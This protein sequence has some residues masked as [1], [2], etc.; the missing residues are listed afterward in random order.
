ML[1]FISL[2][3]ATIAVVI[4]YFV[5]F[6]ATR[7]A[8]SIR[9]FGQVLAAWMFLLAGVVV[10]G[11]LVAPMTG[12]RSPVMDMTEHMQRMEQQNEEILRE[13]QEE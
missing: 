12:F 10:L 7:A 11:G 13:L 8:G 5:L 3:P 9:R 4:G 2:I 1:F 6:S